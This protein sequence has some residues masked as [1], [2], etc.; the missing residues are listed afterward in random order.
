M[1]SNLLYGLL[2]IALGVVLT[3]FGIYALK[4]KIVDAKKKQ[5]P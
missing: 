4:L 2:G 5:K 3:L 1:D